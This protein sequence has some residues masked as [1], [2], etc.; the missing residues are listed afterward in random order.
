VLAASG[1][2]SRERKLA[3]S[4]VIVTGPGAGGDGGVEGS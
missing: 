2:A 3:L 1:P 4:A